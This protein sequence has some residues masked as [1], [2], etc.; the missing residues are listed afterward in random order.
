MK[1][2]FIKF[3]NH[4]IL[5]DLNIDFR[6]DNVEEIVVCREDDPYT[7]KF[8][9][10]TEHMKKVYYPYNTPNIRIPTPQKGNQYANII[11]QDNIHD[12]ILFVGENG[13]GKTTLL[14]ELNNYNKSEYI[15][16]KY[17]KSKV[18]LHS[19]Y[20]KTPLWGFPTTFES[21]FLSRDIK[22]DEGRK[23]VESEI[24][25]TEVDSHDNIS[26]D[27]RSWFN[28]S[29]LSTQTLKGFFDNDRLAN[30]FESAYNFQIPYIM[31]KV[32]RE[33]WHSKPDT[34]IDY[35]KDLS[36][37]EQEI[38]LRLLYFYKHPLSQC[39]DNILIDEPETG[40]HPKW[41]LKVLGY[42]KEIFKLQDNPGYIGQNGKPIPPLNGNQKLQ[43][44]V[45]SHSENILKSAIG[46]GDWLIIRLF[47]DSQGKIT[48]Q[49]IDSSDRR[50][51]K[52]TFAEVQYIVFGVASRDY[53]NELYGALQNQ[54]KLIVGKEVI[55]VKETDHY[56]ASSKVYDR[57]EHEK[58]DRYNTHRKYRN[59][60]DKITEY[61]TLPTKIRNEIDHPPDK[62][63]SFSDYELEKSIELLRVLLK[64]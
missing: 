39:S 17:D 59:G 23:D 54:I 35:I 46:Q 16:Y 29:V 15:E 5:G 1:L 3:S 51:S 55:T 7:E 26:G 10:T 21:S 38:L 30:A 37:G 11:N 4:P 43:L 32:T 24:L 18:E 42:Y 45:A 28:I 25:K 52:I 12:N 31:R 64:N 57:E 53:H 63:I 50:L 2:P 49:R 58:E 27:M 62:G 6:K 14:H 33:Q 61:K 56:I 36:S 48:S 44:F 20:T 60:R 34:M 40:L 47:K 13:C 19:R 9:Y 22:Y 41:Q 8:P